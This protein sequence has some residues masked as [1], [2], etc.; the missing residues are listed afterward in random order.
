VVFAYTVSSRLLRG[1]EGM[2]AILTSQSGMHI[3]RVTA[4]SQAELWQDFV[5]RHSECGNHHRWGWKQVIEE[6]FR[7]PTFYLIAEQGKSAQGILPLVWQKSRMFGSFLTSLPFLN[8][9]GVIAETSTAKTALIAE[10][11]AL[12]KK[13]RVKYLELRHRTDPQLDLPCKMHKVAMVLP[14]EPH[15][16]KMWAKLPHKVRTDIRKG[17]KLGLEAE[18]GREELLDD[19]YEVFARNMRDLGTPVYS[20]QFFAMIL[21]IFQS[22]THICIVRHQ[23]KPVAASFLMGYRGVL[24]AAWSSSL[25]SHISMKP[26]MFLYWEILCFAREQGHQTFDFGRS[27]IGS[28]TYRFKKQWGSHEIPLHWIYWVPDGAELP[29]V[30]KENPRYQLAIRVWQKLPVSV[31]KLIGPSIVKCLP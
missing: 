5:Q 12:A 16:E 31:T 28:G 26:N 7:W 20:R 15:P 1:R 24:E 9:G 10:A 8:S 11:I 22:D 29:E 17:T 13:L 27:S 4:G 3:E 2:G 18:F 19:F 30:N 6:S 21:Q 14:I 25:Y 23:R